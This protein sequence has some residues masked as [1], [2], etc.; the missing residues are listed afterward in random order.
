M[1]YIIGG[2]WHCVGFTSQRGVFI[3]AGALEGCNRC[4]FFLA[5]W[6]LE[7]IHVVGFMYRADTPSSCQQIYMYMCI[8]ARAAL[9]SFLQ[10]SLNR[11]SWSYPLQLLTSLTSMSG[12]S[13]KLLHTG[14]MTCY[15]R[16][17]L[18]IQEV[19]KVMRLVVNLLLWN[20]PY[21][22]GGRY[23]TVIIIYLPQLMFK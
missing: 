17:C 21:P 23:T 13:V 20:R 22:R 1:Y 14:A 5:Y 2:G 12:E 10:W 6:L 16:G 19:G 4:L 15:T 3:V 8:Q 18:G 7:V 9:P 11:T